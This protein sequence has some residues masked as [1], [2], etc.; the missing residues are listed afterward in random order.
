VHHQPGEQLGRVEGLAAA[1]F[2]PLV[3]IAGKTWLEN[4]A[5][6]RQGR[7]QQVTSEPLE[8]SAIVGSHGR[9]ALQATDCKKAGVQISNDA[10]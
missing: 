6:E 3:A 2:R 7:P 5:L 8:T 1:L 4:E 10:R 9:E